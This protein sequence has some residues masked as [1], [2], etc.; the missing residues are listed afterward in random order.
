MTTINNWFFIVLSVAMIAQFGYSH[1]A[2]E[3]KSKWHTV[4]VSVVLIIAF[5]GYVNK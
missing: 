4:Y 1:E 2:K 5:L 3:S